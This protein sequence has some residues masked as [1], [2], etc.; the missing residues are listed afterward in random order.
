M[1]IVKINQVR[2]L[3][4]EALVKASGSIG[5]AGYLEGHLVLAK[6]GCPLAEC[7]V[8]YFCV[9]KCKELGGVAHA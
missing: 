3:G 7:Q 2:R 1:K 6:Q 8:G 5:M 9:E 4:T